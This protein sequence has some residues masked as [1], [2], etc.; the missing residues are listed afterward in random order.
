[1]L[2]LRILNV[3]LLSVTTCTEVSNLLFCAQSKHAHT[4]TETSESEIQYEI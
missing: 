3:G 2:S 1:M 4:K